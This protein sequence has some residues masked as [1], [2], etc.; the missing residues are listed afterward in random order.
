MRLPQ[1]PTIAS[2][3][4]I[5]SGRTSWDD[6]KRDTAFSRSEARSS[7]VG[8]SLNPFIARRHRAN[9]RQ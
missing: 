5:H 1:Q 6:L 8:V 2:L 7:G 3:A 4:S 9:P